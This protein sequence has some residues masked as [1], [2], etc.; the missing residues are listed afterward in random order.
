MEIV[1][2]EVRAAFRLKKSTEKN[3]ESM[4]FEPQVTGKD[5]SVNVDGDTPLR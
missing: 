3:A 1:A 5:H 4:S 2:L